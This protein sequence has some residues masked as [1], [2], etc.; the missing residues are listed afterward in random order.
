MTASLVSVASDHVRWRASWKVEKFDDADFASPR[1]RRCGLHL[2]ERAKAG[3]E[4]PQRLEIVSAGITPYDVV[5]GEGNLLLNNGITR[6]WNLIIGTGSILGY[7]QSG[8]SQMRIGTGN[9]S[10][11]VTAADTDLSASAG[12]TNRWFQ[13][14]DASNPTVSAQ[15][16]TCIAT[17]ASADGN[18]AWTEWGV[19]GGGSTSGN[20]VGTNSSTVNAL[21]NRKVP[22]ASLGTKASGASWAFTI[23]IVLS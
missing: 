11:S 10:T 19:D 20:T 15:T 13:K 17:F 7:A 16:M 18:Y 23:T 4:A 3:L 14:S 1:G 9:G 2:P 21:M 6:M 8:T 22:G 12:S 5:E